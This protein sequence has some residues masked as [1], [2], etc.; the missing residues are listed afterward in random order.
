MNRTTTGLDGVSSAQ[1]ERE[2]ERERGREGETLALSLCKPVF[3]RL[4]GRAPPGSFPPGPP[5]AGPR[6]KLPPETPKGSPCWRCLAGWGLDLGRRWPRSLH[7]H[8]MMMMHAHSLPDLGRRHAISALGRA[9]NGWHWQLVHSLTFYKKLW[10]LK[11]PEGIN[12][13]LSFKI[14]TQFRI[15]PLRT[16]VTCLR[17]RELRSTSTQNLPYPSPFYIPLLTFLLLKAS[18][19]KTW[20]NISKAS[21]LSEPFTSPD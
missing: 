12:H 21:S 17:V 2:R 18:T 4:P 13:F 16:V 20:K 1:R 7:A 10:S 19:E 3:L 5:P 6:E 15:L 11:H 14:K 9:R 8:G